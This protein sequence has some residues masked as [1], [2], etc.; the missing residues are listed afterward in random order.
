MKKLSI[1]FN[2]VIGMIAVS[3]V[4]SI[5]TAFRESKKV[6]EPVPHTIPTPAMGR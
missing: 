3:F 1:A 6:Q 4:L 2:A 5:V